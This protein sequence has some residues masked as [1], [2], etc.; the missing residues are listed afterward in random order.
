MIP[1]DQ[2]SALTLL[3]WFYLNQGFPVRASRLYRSLALIDPDDPAHCRGLAVAQ[4]AAGKA[5]AALA[6]L[7]Q[8]ALRGAIDGPYHAVRARALASL[9][10][11]TEAAAAM[12]A[13]VDYRAAPPPT[14]E[15]N[16]ALS[17][18]AGNR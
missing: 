7:D 1:A 13:Y 4:L 5:D 17:R 15:P 12:R 18:A 8:L 3:A 2:K 10:R 14:D 9:G 16:T 11:Q 6:A